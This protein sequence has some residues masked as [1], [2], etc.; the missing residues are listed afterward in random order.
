METG[1]IKMDTTKRCPHNR[2]LW[3]GFGD[4]K[5]RHYSESGN[6]PLM[7]VCEQATEAR[8]EYRA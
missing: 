2:K 6:T 7:I 1:I 8:E 5:A 3:W 4:G